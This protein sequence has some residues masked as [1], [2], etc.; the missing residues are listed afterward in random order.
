MS[1]RHF[2]NL[3]DYAQSMGN[4]TASHKVDSFDE[5]T[6]FNVLHFLS[7]D[8]HNTTKA[9]SDITHQSMKE[10]VHLESNHMLPR[11]RYLLPVTMKLMHQLAHVVTSLRDRRL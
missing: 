3:N 5:Y 7:K 10:P 9:N 4:E 1:E 8:Q 2:Q 11:L 6:G